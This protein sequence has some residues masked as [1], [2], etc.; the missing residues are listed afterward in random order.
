LLD[1]ALAEF[2]EHGFDG[3]STRAIAARAS[4]H[5]PQINYHFTSKDELWRAA[6]DHLMT[7]FDEVF[8]PVR[9][10]ARPG[11]DHDAREV[12]A[13]VVRGLCR[14]AAERPELNRIMIQEGTASSD[15]LEWI[16]ER[17]LRARHDFIVAIWSELLAE[18]RAAPVDPEL[19]HY[20]LVGAAS[21]VYANAPEA[22]LLLGVDPTETDRVTAHAETLIA[23]L[24]PEPV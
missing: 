16:V 7:S 13:E 9:R 2:S 23:L 12:F 1:A 21:L 18:G 15:R 22:R 3:A 17:H 19:I 20:L 4:A 10:S 8:A 11:A 5:Q 6:V 14:F 24:L